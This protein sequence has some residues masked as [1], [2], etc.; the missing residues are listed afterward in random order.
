MG[1]EWMRMRICSLYRSPNIERMTKYRRLRWPGYVARMEEDRSAFK[2]L[3]CKPKGK[4]PIGRLSQIT[5]GV[6]DANS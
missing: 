4:R 1:P 5:L 2:I 6:Q 3:T